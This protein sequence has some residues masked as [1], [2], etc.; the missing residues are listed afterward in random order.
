MRE[1]EEGLWGFA[2]NS[3][4]A[5]YVLYLEVRCLFVQ[6]VADQ[7]HHVLF[8]VPSLEDL[9]EPRNVGQKCLEK[10]RKMF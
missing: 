3:T 9:Q 2:Q 4:V 10:Q 8:D 1:R 6:G 5:Q 7:S